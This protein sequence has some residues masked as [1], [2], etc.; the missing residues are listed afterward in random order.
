MAIAIHPFPVA[1]F[2]ATNMVFFLGLYCSANTICLPTIF[3]AR[4]PIQ[5]ITRLVTETMMIVPPASYITVCTTEQEKE[6]KPN[7]PH[8]RRSAMKGSQRRIV[9]CEKGFVTFSQNVDV[10]EVPHL[11]DLPQEE[12]IA[13]WYNNQD[14]ER[15]KKSLVITL[16]L[17]MAQKP[18]GSDQCVRGL[19]FRTPQGAKFRKKTKIDALTAVWNEQ[20]AQWK[21]NKTDDEAIRRVYVQHSLKCREAARKFGLHDEQAVQ[22]YLHGETPEEDDS[23]CSSFHSFGLPE[24]EN[25]EKMNDDGVSTNHTIEDIVVKQSCAPSAA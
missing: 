12:K 14:F 8:K 5:S 3:Y 6:Q 11:K 10:Q 20:V 16:R 4:S 19:E 1:V 17:M 24:D 18:V 9:P 22:N 21:E 15:I 13:T 2:N 7:S 25:K 23:C